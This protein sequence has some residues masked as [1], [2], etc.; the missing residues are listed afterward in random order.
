MLS[1]RAR[2][3]SRTRRGLLLS[4]ARSHLFNRVLD[5]RI[6]AG[7]W[8]T[9]LPGEPAILAGSRSLFVPEPDDAAVSERLRALDISPSGPLPGAGEPLAHG[10]C[11]ALERGVLADESLLCDGLRNAGVDAARRPLRVPV[12][13]LQCCLDGATLTFRFSLPPG[14][15]ATALLDTLGRTTQA[16]AT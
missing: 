13:D 4:A 15:Y 12:P 2:R 9:L 6:A 11:A 5:A 8:L 16:T 1:P 3:V 10:A 14:S 7:N